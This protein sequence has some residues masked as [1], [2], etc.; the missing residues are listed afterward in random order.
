MAKRS[1]Q[2][3][4]QKIDPQILIFDVDGVLVDVRETFWRSAIQTVQQ[5][6]GKKVT[7]KEL[8]EWKRKP[9]NN[10]DWQ[11]VSRWATSLGTPTTYEQARIA[12]QPF[13]WGSNGNPGNVSREKLLVSPKLIRKWARNREL[14]LFTGRTRQEFDYTFEGWPARNCFRTVITM[15]DAPRKKPYPDG[16]LAIL[17]TRRPHTALYLGDNIDDALSAKAAGVPF[18]AV[19][20]KSSYDYRERA[21]KFR[22]LNA[23]ALLER[24]RDLDYWLE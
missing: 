20:P 13:Y 22:E 8:Y 23:L 16:L 10:D 11:L 24:A 9:G 18:M 17:G 7:W 6:T 3:G 12:F 1:D 4:S 5:L 21:R 14:N 15:N 19:L 2:T